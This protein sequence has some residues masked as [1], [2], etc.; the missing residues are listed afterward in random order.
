MKFVLCVVRD[1]DADQ[2]MHNLI[3]QGFYVTRLAST[4][5]FLRVGNTIL[6]S[7]VE[8]ERVGALMEIVRASTHVHA[9]APPSHLLET[10]QA[11]RAVV[12]VLNLERLERL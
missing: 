9:Q 8:D 12:F 6:F 11:S 5:G 2:V 10:V 4:G 3:D 7:G 1:D